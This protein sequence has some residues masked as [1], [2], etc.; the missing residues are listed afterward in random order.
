[1][2]INSIHVPNLRVSAVLMIN[3]AVLVFTAS[4]AV[5]QD[6][7]LPAGKPDVFALL[8]SPP[9]P[10]SPEQNADLA[11]V[12]SVVKNRTPQE[13]ARGK[14]ESDFTYATFSMAI[15]PILQADKL[16]KTDALMREVLAE[17]KTVIDAGKN[18]WQRVRPYE[19]DPQLLKGAKESSFGYPSGHSTR[20]TVDALLLAELFPD[21]RD[22]ILALGRQIGWDR[23]VLGRHYETDVFAGRVLAQ[24]IVNQLHESP[25]FQ[26]DFAAAKAEIE[27]ARANSNSAQPDSKASQPQAM[28]HSIDS[29]SPSMK[30]G[31]TQK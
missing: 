8:P 7:Y 21:R 22:A 15:G 18:H 28:I 11:E 25:K 12:E 16:P 5:A 6:R 10:S 14:S 17:S 20:A 24:A 31:D 4:V 13:E 29:N 23:V 19:L 9:A 26:H 2:R 1:M 30:D 3:A 27:A